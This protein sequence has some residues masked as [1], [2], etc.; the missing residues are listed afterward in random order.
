MII[1]HLAACTRNPSVRFGRSL[2]MMTGCIGL[3]LLSGCASAG[4]GSDRVP[5]QIKILKE[6]PSPI[7]IVVQPGTPPPVASVIEVNGATPE[8]KAEAPGKSPD[9]KLVWQPGSWR[10]YSSRYVWEKG[11][12]VVPPKPNALYTPAKWEIVNGNHMFTEGY[13]HF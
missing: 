7:K 13:W 6:T 2:A 9:P 10:F 11:R 12:W 1:S 3:T 5:N 4:I 8:P